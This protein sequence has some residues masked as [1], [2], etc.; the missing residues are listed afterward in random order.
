[1]TTPFQPVLGGL[2][3]QR[4]VT[5]ALVV[6]EHDGI[7]VDQ[8]VQVG[9]RGDVVAALAASLYRR[10]RQAATSAG[11]GETGVLQLDAETGRVCAVGRGDLVLVVVTEP[12]A[13]VGLVR[14]EMLKGLEA[15]A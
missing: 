11:F 1:M 3:R 8:V 6:S 14:V 10:A 15:L 4:G 9:V 13:N 7:V 5:G 2:I 12:T